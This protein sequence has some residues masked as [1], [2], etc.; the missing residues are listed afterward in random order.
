[1][2]FF[3]SRYVQVRQKN[4]EIRYLLLYGTIL[5]VSVKEMWILQVYERDMKNWKL[6][7]YYR[8][9]KHKCPS[10]HSYLRIISCYYKVVWEVHDVLY[11]KFNV[12]LCF[13]FV[14]QGMKVAIIK[15][16][17]K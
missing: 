15:A 4:S 12:I 1:M 3:L 6:L 5:E 2:Y 16:P 10:W 11:C 7:L 17:K 13:L 9:K 14:V 8:D